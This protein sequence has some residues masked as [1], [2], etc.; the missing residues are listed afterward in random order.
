[1]SGN[2]AGRPG[3]HPT[4]LEVID[5]H[6]LRGRDAVV[7]GGGSGLGYQT[8][9]ALAAAG[10]RV[11]LAVRD[12]T[13]AS[14]AAAA[15]RAQPGSPQVD[16]A[17]LRLDSLASVRRFV[18]WYKTTGRPLHLLINNAG[19]MATPLSYTHDGF[20]SQF[21][22]NYLGHFALSVG[23]L[24][25]LQ[26]AARPAWWSCRQPPTAAPT[27]TSPTSTSGA[28]PTTPSWPTGSPRPP[29]RCLRSASAGNTPPTA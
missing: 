29:T 22:V 20:E 8:A 5:G 4:A 11:V 27:S 14:A 6:D 25:A 26:A 18:T 23:L 2:P 28:D 21:G 16:L 24:P 3:R 13:R 1:M 12:T 10:A 17:P 19:I 9:R 7:T 15:L